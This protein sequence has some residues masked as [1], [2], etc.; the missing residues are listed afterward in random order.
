MGTPFSIY[1]TKGKVYV[2]SWYNGYPSRIAYRHK[3]K[4]FAGEKDNIEIEGSMYS[5]H[6]LEDNINSKLDGAWSTHKRQ[7]H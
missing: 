2:N 1:A 4:I 6:K 7:Y 3:N 5:T